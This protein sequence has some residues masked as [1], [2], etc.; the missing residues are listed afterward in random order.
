VVA[1]TGVTDLCAIC[2]HPITFHGDRA[3]TACDGGFT[4][5]PTEFLTLTRRRNAVG[6]E[7]GCPG[8]AAKTSV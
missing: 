7:C 8:W 1:G 6:P 5:N 4:L 3:I 2:E